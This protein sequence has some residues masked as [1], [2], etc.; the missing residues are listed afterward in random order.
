[1]KR[2]API[3][4][5]LSCAEP[6]PP[7][8]AVRALRQHYER[9]GDP[10]AAAAYIQA[11]L[12]A[13]T[14]EIRRALLEQVEAFPDPDG[15]LLDPLLKAIGD[16][17]GV[18]E[19]MLRTAAARTRDEATEAMTR[20]L[21]RERVSGSDARQIAVRYLGRAARIGRPDALDF[22]TRLI[23]AAD[24]SLARAID[25]ELALLAGKVATGNW[26]GWYLAHAAKTRWGWLAEAAGGWLGEPFD[27]AN[28]AHIDKV[29][30]GLDPRQE[31]E[32]E[33]SL[34][35]PLL[36]RRFGYVSPRYAFAESEIP[37]P[38]EAVKRIRDWWTENGPRA[39]YDQGTGRWELK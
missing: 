33:F 30:A 4:L 17:E 19:G 15:V 6:R 16:A 14:A 12:Q 28:R 39:R 23:P 35:E 26:R 36:G 20:Y 27:P 8:E 2:L 31:L 11:V 18:T 10:A 24:E 38:E 13:P 29:L 37:P 25:E 7:A 1:M 9:T 22:L 32:P 5:L 21:T 34:L 3:V